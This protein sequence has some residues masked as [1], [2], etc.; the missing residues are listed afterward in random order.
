M[1]PYYKSLQVNN[2]VGHGSVI[3]LTFKYEKHP[4]FNDNFWKVKPFYPSI[5][6]FFSINGLHV[7]EDE[8][9][10]FGVGA[11]MEKN[12]WALI[13]RELSLFWRL[14]ILPP[15]CV[16]PFASWKTHEGQFPSVGIL[17]KQVIGIPRSQIETKRMFGLVGVL[18]TLGHYHL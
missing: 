18:T 14:V 1:D 13:N 6:G 10:M 16:D 11:S 5:G 12:S 3:H 7:E 9:N 4:T 2:Y 15:M 8:S 17:T